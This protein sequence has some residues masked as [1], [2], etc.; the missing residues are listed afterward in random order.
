M[1]KKKKVK[2]KTKSASKK[3]RASVRNKMIK[4]SPLIK[5]A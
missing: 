1:A 3:K 5:A 4:T 2:A